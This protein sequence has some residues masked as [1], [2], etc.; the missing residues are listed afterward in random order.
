MKETLLQILGILVISGTLAFGTNALRAHG[1]PLVEHWSSKLLT[2]EQAAGLPAVSL[3]EAVRAYGRGEAVFVDARP[4]AFFRLGH[5]PGALSLPLD[6]FDR[7]FPLLKKQLL[8]APQIIAYCDGASC[9]TSMGLTGKLLMAGLDQVA[10]FTG[11]MEQWQA[12]G[13]R[14]ETGPG[15][16]SP[17]GNERAQSPEQGAQSQR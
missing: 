12:A 17:T 5:I 2:Q 9:E 13:Q 3:A 7:V 1:I 14:V 16:S 10:V 8:S 6:D 11:G 15:E 4:A